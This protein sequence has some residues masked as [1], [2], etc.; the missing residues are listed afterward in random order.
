M[1]RSTRHHR[2][3]HLGALLALLVLGCVS[4]SVA[5]QRITPRPCVIEPKLIGTWKSS[6]FSQLGPAS[7]KFSFG[8]DCTYESRVRVL[9]LMSIRERG[10]YAAKDG[11]L[12]FSRASG[13][14]T[15]WPY[16][17]EEDRL[18]LDESPDESR[19]Y[20]RTKQQKCTDAEGRLNP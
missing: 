20:Q 2:T 8:C 12:I 13:D 18:I 15:T 7:M 14:I 19:S 4:S 16:R 1:A 11:E 3:L 9:L 17:F 6:R 10:S 5:P